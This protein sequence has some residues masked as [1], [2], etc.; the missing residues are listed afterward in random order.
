V[1]F[2]GARNLYPH[3]LYAFPQVKKHDRVRRSSPTYRLFAALAALLF[4]LGWGA[5]VVQAA[6]APSGSP[7]SGQCGGPGT[8]QHCDVGEGSASAVCLSHHANGE[9]LASGPTSDLHPK[10]V[11]GNGAI[12]RVA[13]SPRALHSLCLS[14]RRAVLRASRLHARVRVWLE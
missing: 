14:F 4:G 2:Y 10:A 3:P 12:H 7:L 8:T 11:G 9:A 6:C 5:P 13:P 1:S